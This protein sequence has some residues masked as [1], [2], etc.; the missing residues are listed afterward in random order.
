MIRGSASDIIKNG[1][2]SLGELK[3]VGDDKRSDFLSL[4]CATMFGGY[5]VDEEWLRYT[6]DLKNKE[7]QKGNSSEFKEGLRSDGVTV[8]VLVNNLAV[9][10]PSWSFRPCVQEQSAEIYITQEFKDSNKIAWGPVG[11]KSRESKPFLVYLWSYDL[12]VPARPLTQDQWPWLATAISWANSV[13]APGN[14]QIVVGSKWILRKDRDE[15]KSDRACAV[16]TM[17]ENLEKKLQGKENAKKK[18]EEALAGYQ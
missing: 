18:Y 11:G 1:L 7:T 10:A 13:P 16:L 14:E 2:G 4:F 17:P 6:T 15:I 3:N 8:K 9:P 12:R 5:L